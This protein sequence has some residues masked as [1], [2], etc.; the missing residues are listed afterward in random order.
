MVERI[1]RSKTSQYYSIFLGVCIG[2][3]LNGVLNSGRDAYEF[4]FKTIF[5][6]SVTFILY[7]LCIKLLDLPFFTMLR[8]SLLGIAITS[9]IFALGEVIGFYFFFWRKF[10]VVS[11]LY[12]FR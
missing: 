10:W 4:L 7:W 1:A 12:C 2:V 8:L 3:L 5:G 9:F 11:Y 6:F